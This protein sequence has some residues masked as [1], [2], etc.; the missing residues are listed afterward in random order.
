MNCDKKMTYDNGVKH[1]FYHLFLYYKN[2]I[3]VIIPG[4]TFEN[5]CKHRHVH[6]YLVGLE[7]IK[8]NKP[9]SAAKT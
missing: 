8:T 2:V 5:F 4:I 9:T 6:V 7:C 3:P 1:I